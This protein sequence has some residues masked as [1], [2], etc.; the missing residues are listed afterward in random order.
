MSDEERIYRRLSLIYRQLFK[1]I[2]DFECFI[3]DFQG[4]IVFWL[5]AWIDDAKK[6]PLPAGYVYGRR[7]LLG[8]IRET[9]EPSPCFIFPKR[10]L[11]FFP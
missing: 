8:K 10:I 5:I 11:V 9:R 4:D 6:D 3:V 7:A 1:Y 2:I